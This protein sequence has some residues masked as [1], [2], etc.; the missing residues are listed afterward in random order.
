MLLVAH[1]DERGQPASVI[2]MQ[3]A[4][5]DG[6]H[7]AQRVTCFGDLFGGAIAG[8]DEDSVLVVPK[9]IRRLGPMR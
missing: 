2:D 7:L 6:V 3:M 4:E 9:Q 5:D 1:A 8:V